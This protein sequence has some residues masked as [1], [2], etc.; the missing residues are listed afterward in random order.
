MQ[1]S[2]RERYAIV[3]SSITRRVVCDFDKAIVRRYLGEG[4]ERS[5]FS[6]SLKHSI[7]TRP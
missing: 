3:S 4:V 7:G 1:T 2:L 6:A 5:A